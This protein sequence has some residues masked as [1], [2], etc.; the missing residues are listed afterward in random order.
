MRTFWVA[1][2]QVVIGLIIVFLVYAMSLWILKQDK[3]VV[4]E[5]RQHNVTK[6]FKIIDGYADTPL[7]ANRNWNP[8][9][10]VAKNFTPLPRSYNRK[11]GAQFSYSFW[12][13]LDDTS[14]ENVA[15]KDILVRGDTKEYTYTRETKRRAKPNKPISGE[16][17]GEGENSQ[18]VYDDLETETA[19]RTGMA[20]KCPRIRFGPTYDTLVVELN[21]QHDIDHAVH[22]NSISANGVDSTLR[23]NVLKLIEHKWVLFTFVF[24]DNVAI[25]EFEDGIVFRFYINDLLYHTARIKSTLRQNNGTLYLLP[26]ES[27]SSGIKNARLGD[28]TYYNYAVNGLQIRDVYKRGPPKHYAKDIGRDTVGSPLYLSVYNEMDIY[29][30]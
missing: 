11:G 1:L 13:F 16:G 30:T 5:R 3:L 14:P 21:T 6:A 17:E 23:H 8:L 20:I 19:T 4:D 12:L 15:N 10:P 7:L 9:N 29:N 24:E 22:I 28:L 26:A 18:R 27:N 2:L 25:N